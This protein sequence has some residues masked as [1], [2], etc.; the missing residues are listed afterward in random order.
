MK[1]SKDPKD[2]N[3]TGKKKKVAFTIPVSTANSACLPIPSSS[4]ITLPSSSVIQEQVATMSLFGNKAPGLSLN[5]GAANAFGTS[6]KPQPQQGGGLFGN[7]QSNA[8]GSSLFGN[9]Q[10]NPSGGGIF[11]NVN[12]QSQSQQPGGL[13]GQSQQQQ[14]SNQTQGGGLF[15]QSQN[16]GQG[17][18]GSMNA[19]NKP[20]IFSQSLNTQQ[21]LA[22]NQRASLFAQ[23]A[24]SQPI[25]A[26]PLQYG[27]NMTP[28]QFVQ[29]MIPGVRIDLSNIKPTTRFNDLDEN[30]QKDLEKIDEYIQSQIKNKEECDVLMQRIGSTIDN[31]PVEVEYLTYKVQNMQ[32]ALEN[33]AAS[34]D[35]VRFLMKGDVDDAQKIFRAIDAL[36]FPQQYQTQ[37]L[38]N[39][40][41]AQAATVTGSRLPTSDGEDPSPEIIAYFNKELEKMG[42]SIEDYKKILL[43]VENHLQAREQTMRYEA[44][45]LAISGGHLPA[46]NQIKELGMAFSEV[47]GA[48]VRMAGRIAEAREDVTKIVQLKGY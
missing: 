42:K 15:G 37:G 36:R 22:Q 40:P 12:N 18:L 10:N 46:Q 4:P 20:S 23:A 28:A 17:L 41:A 7:A 38:W 14:S 45:Q 24:P 1:S 13:F 39:H 27:S 35:N 30:L 3:N 8:G 29:G 5:T 48:I 16:Q 31:I 19:Q 11:G 2:G 47:E 26:P 44:Q 33:D 32:H 43:N 9:T 21:P 25:A 34:I 6:T